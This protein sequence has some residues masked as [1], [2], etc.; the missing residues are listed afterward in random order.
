MNPGAMPRTDFRFTSMA[1]MAKKHQAFV[2]A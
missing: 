1:E 2:R